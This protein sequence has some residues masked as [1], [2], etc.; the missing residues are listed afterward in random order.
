IQG[1]RSSLTDISELRRVEIAL[2]E[3]E[4]SVQSI[5]RAAPVGIGLVAERVLLKVNDTVCTMLGYS[6][7]ELIGRDARILYP[8][9]DDYDYVGS[10]KYGQIRK[11]GTGSVETRWKTKDGSIIDILL[12]ST[13]LVPGDL[14]YGVTFTA[15]DITERKRAEQALRKEHDLVARIS[16]TSPVGIVQLD[17]SGN[18]VFAN[19]RAGQILE[20]DPG[21]LRQ[22]K[23]N[24][25]EWR[26]TDFDG[27]PFRDEKLAFSKVKQTRKPV[28]DVRHAIEKNDG[29]RILLSINGAPLLRPDGLFEGA[30]MTIE[31]ITRRHEIEQELQKTERLESLSIL[32]GGIAH[33][34]NNLLGGMYGYMDMALEYGEPNPEVREYLEKAMRSYQRAKDLTQQ[35]LT[36]SKGG[37]PIKKTGSFQQVAKDAI[38]LALSGSNVRCV[39]AVDDG[40]WPVDM[41]EGQIS[42]V[43]NNLIIN[44]RHAM[45]QGGTIEAGF[46]NRIIQTE[47]G[48]PVDEGKYVEMKIKDHGIGISDEHLERIFDPFFTTKQQG[49]GLGLATSFSIIKRHGGH[50]AVE[51]ELGSGTEFSVYLPAVESEYTFQD[52]DVA[53]VETGTGRILLMDDETAIKEM[54]LEMLERLGYTVTVCSDGEEALRLYSGAFELGEPYDCVILDLT[55]PG[56]LGGRETVTR[57]IQMDPSVKTIASSGYSEDPVMAEPHKYGFK[58]IIAKPYLLKKMS[59]VIRDVLNQAR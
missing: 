51:S 21:D 38:S 13:P 15:L 18:I 35:L 4:A 7:D 56:G 29:A 3:S 2:K 24:S 54:A 57:L 23:Y 20:T 8:T 37:M 9:N 43:V 39:Y 16:A 46:Y 36:F 48:M 40:L 11:S 59:A 33:D 14:S 10:E 17:D 19:Q 27:A 52:E 26:I 53:T 31:D 30:V 6:P 34:F 41:D 22:R 45:P 58:G 50:I 42:Q 1:V 25:P 12:S 49:S 44:A 55:V 47:D 28:Y 5:F 32:A